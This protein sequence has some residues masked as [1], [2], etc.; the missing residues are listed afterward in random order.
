M[1]WVQDDENEIK[2]DETRNLKTHKLKKIDWKKC[3]ILIF[4]FKQIFCIYLLIK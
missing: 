3:L 2:N 1:I 4:D